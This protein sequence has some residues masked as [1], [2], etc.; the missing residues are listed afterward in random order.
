MGGLSDLSYVIPVA[1]TAPNHLPRCKEVTFP[2]HLAV[3][4]L[5]VCCGPTAS[6]K[7]SRPRNFALMPYDGEKVN[8]D[9]L[10]E[11]GPMDGELLAY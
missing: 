7:R 6:I 11:T 8:Q 9:E 1:M 4:L 2:R 5:L 10:Y 3:D